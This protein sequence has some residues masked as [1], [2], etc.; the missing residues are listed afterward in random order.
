MSVDC[1]HTS[2]TVLHPSVRV[3]CFLSRSHVGCSRP[4]QR[5]LIYLIQNKQ[6]GNSST[7]IAGSLLRDFLPVPSILVREA[8]TNFVT[9]CGDLIEGD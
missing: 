5:V 9:L 6:K 4:L 8:S 2:F 1:W 7:D 3:L